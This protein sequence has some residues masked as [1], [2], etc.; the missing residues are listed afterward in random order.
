MSD[1]FSGLSRALREALSELPRALVQE[2][3]QRQTIICLLYQAVR[4]MGLIPVPGWRP[5]RSTRDSIDL[6][7]VHP[8]SDPPQIEVAF[9][10]SPLVELTLVKALEWVECPSKVIVTFSER[11]DKVRQSTFFLGKDHIHLNLHD[12]AK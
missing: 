6:V 8:Q 2:E 7:G 9:A 10:V 5:P 3:V 4:G 12:Q 1:Q 11:A